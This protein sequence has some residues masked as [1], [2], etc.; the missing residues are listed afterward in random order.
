MR[1]Y[2]K[3]SLYL[4]YYVHIENIILRILFSYIQIAWILFFFSAIDH[5]VY[6]ISLLFI[7]IL[8]T[9]VFSWL[10][11][12]HDGSICILYIYTYLYIYVPFY[13]VLRKE[14]SLNIHEIVNHALLHSVPSFLLSSSFPVLYVY[15]QGRVQDHDHGK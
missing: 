9:F 13:I 4:L 10:Q 3:F 12:Y 8:I 6:S 2:R 7:V 1:V 5:C 14:L 11:C 15:A